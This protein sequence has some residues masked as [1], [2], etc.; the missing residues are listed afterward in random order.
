MYAIMTRE[1][2]FNGSSR[3]EIYSSICIGRYKRPEGVEE[4]K[5][6]EGLLDVNPARR[7]GLKDVL[8]SDWRNSEE[9]LELVVNF[10]ELVVKE[11]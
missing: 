6:I 3:H 7:W 5:L 1:M 9:T 11:H 4:R 8:K 10:S 2:A